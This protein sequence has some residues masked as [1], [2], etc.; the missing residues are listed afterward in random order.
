MS[1]QKT[2]AV[3]VI[4]V[5]TPKPGRMEAFVAAQTEALQTTLRDRI[6]GW[7]GT[8]MYR[9]LDDSAAA[10]VSTFAS[11]EEYRAW[12]ASDLFARHR[13]TI[14]PLIER[15]GPQLY[16]QVYAAGEP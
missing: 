14:A 13:E 5:F 3:V 6:P 16:R 1:P 12:M 9:A 15:A 11:V 7:R 8:R 4:N 2:E 10:L